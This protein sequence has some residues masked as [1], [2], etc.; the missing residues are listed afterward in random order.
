[1]GFLLR[2]W[3]LK[4]AAVALATILYTGLVFSGTFSEDTIRVRI[5][6]ANVSRDAFVLSGDLGLV[7]VRYRVANGQANDEIAEALFLSPATVKTHVNRTMT[8]LG[9]HDRAGLV[10]AAYE[11]GLVRPG[12]QES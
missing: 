6:Q 11:S 12:R 3:Q 10:I 9:V 2:N 5:D 4:L 1:M 8:K 7:E